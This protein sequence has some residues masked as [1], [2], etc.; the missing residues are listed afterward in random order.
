MPI[1][2]AQNIKSFKDKLPQHVQ[3][4]AISKTKPISYIKEAYEAGQ[5]HF[6]ENKIQEMTEKAESLPEDICWHMVGHVQGN[7]I[8]YMAPYVH[9]VHG[10][11]K[12]KRLKELNKEAKKNDRVINCLL[13]V[14]I[15]KEETKFGFS[16]KEAL[17]TLGNAP[18]EKYPNVNIAGLMAMATNTNQEETVRNEFREMK[19]LFSKAHTLYPADGFKVLSTGMSGDYKIAIEEG[20]NMI[21]IG[22][23]IFGKRD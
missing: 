6:G 17:E 1:N 9:M 20:S 18:Q 16:P 2:V 12:P 10:I 13:Q 11:D 23:A 4:V 3:L 22:T 8:K 14:H 19:V 7:K 15:A 21:R 5:R